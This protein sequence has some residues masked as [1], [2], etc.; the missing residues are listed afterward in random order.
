MEISLFFRAKV[1]DARQLLYRCNDAPAWAAA[2][3]GSDL[4]TKPFSGWTAIFS[5]PPWIIFPASV[6]SACTGSITRP[7]HGLPC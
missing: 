7:K 6:G 3:L 1:A 4:M 5:I 2:G